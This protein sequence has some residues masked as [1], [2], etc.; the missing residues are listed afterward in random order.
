MQATAADVTYMQRALALARGGIGF[1]SPNPLVGCVIVKDGRVVGEGYH[2]RFGGPHA[3]VHALREAGAQVHKA[4]LYVN[5][6]PCCHTDETPPCIEAI[7]QAGIGR[8]VVAVPDPNPLVSGGGLARLREAGVA[9]TT[10]VCEAEGRR[11]NEAFLHYITTQRPFITLKC[12][13]TLDGKIATHTGAS[14]WITGAPA[15]EAVHHMRHAT[16]ALLVGVGTVLQDNPLLTTRLPHGEGVNPLRVVADSTLR[17]PLTAQLTTVS[18]ACRTLVATT[19]WASATKQR[20]LE[21]RGVEILRLQAYD[22]RVDVNALFHA[23]GARGIASLLVEGGATLSATLVQ[24]R[25]VQKVVMFVAPKII[26]G[27]GMSVIGA[28]GVDTM[29]QAII[30]HNMTSHQVGNDLMLE[31]YLMPREQAAGNVPGQGEEV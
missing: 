26:G 16:D 21:E 19:P 13:I 27:D 1:V 7:L 3:E 6:E 9:V 14:R 24:Q 25:L 31:A 29:E 8:V 11:L 20:Q 23:L 30:L 15:R 4:V 2:R 12:A 10:G 22:G 17:L 28:C 18:A 5:L